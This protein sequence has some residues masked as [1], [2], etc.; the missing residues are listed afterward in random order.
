ME[1]S[2]EEHT[3]LKGR[4]HAL[5][6]A[7]GRVIANDASL[8]VAFKDLLAFELTLLF[9]DLDEESVEDFRIGSRDAI[10]HIL[11]IANRAGDK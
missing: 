7:L 1:I 2:A 10:T 9:D 5:E 6:I 4:I 11:K 8:Q 3:R